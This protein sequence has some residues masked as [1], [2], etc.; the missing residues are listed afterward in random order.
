[1]ETGTGREEVLMTK[2]GVQLERAQ[3]DE[4]ENESKCLQWS[5]LR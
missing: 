3:K 1:M 5:S 4:A 2:A